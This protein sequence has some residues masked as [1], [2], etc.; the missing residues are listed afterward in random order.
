[1]G[2][3]GK[4]QRSL[5]NAVKYATAFPVII[6]SAAQKLLVEEEGEDEARTWYGEYPLFRLW[7]VVFLLV[8]PGP[9]SFMMSRKATCGYR[10]LSLLVLVG[11]HERLG[12]YPT[13]IRVLESVRPVHALSPPLNSIRITTQL[14]VYRSPRLFK[15][16]LA[17]HPHSRPILLLRRPTR[18]TPPRH[19]LF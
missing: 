19:H 8:E 3:G 13:E 11:R 6:L 15:F 17:P 14:R 12:S 9:F 1:M 4:S 18:N 7:Y 5:Y 16:T 10:Q 2:S